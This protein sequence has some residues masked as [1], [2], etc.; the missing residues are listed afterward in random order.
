MGFFQLFSIEITSTA[1]VLSMEGFSLISWIKVWLLSLGLSFEALGPSTGTWP[2]GDLWLDSFRS[3]D[4]VLGNGGVEPTANVEHPP[5]L[6]S[7]H[8]V[9]AVTQLLPPPPSSPYPHRLQPSPPC[10]TVDGIARTATVSVLK[11]HST[12]SLPKIDFILNAIEE[13]Q[14]QDL[15]RNGSGRYLIHCLFSSYFTIRRSSFVGP[16]REGE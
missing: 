14:V 3:P 2:F 1:W 5:P 6:S 11:S 10:P 12:S 13:I 16:R 15:W 4:V 7:I 8:G 9:V